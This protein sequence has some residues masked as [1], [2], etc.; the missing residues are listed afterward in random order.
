MT[1]STKI[2]VIACFEPFNSMAETSF[3]L[4]IK[5]HTCEAFRECDEQV[6]EKGCNED[7]SLS[8]SWVS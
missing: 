2:D 6:R 4:L 3:S 5:R 1:E 7:C 8:A